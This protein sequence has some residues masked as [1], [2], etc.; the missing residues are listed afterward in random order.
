MKDQE[1]DREIALEKKRKKNRDRRLQDRRSSSG[2]RARQLR[3]ACNGK[4]GNMRATDFN[5]RAFGT[6]NGRER[7]V[8]AESNAAKERLATLLA[9]GQPVD[10]GYEPNPEATPAKPNGRRGNAKATNK[11]QPNEVRFDKPKRAKKATS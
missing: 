5:D 6:P 3:R 2:K 10:G 1:I 4:F 8:H 11:P 9:E 7:D